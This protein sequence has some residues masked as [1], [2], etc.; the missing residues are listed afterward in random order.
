VSRERSDN[1]SDHAK[2]DLEY[3]QYGHCNS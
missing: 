2:C 3:G 1:D